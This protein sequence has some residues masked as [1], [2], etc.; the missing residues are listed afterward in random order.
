MS[1]IKA[2]A[3]QIGQSNTATENFTLEVPSSPDGTIKLA[4]GNAGATTQDVLSV[5]ASGNVAFAGITSLGDISNATVTATSTTTARD[6]ATRFADVINVLDFGADPTGAVDSTEAFQN[7]F[8]A[9]GGYI[10]SGNY[11]ISET[12]ITNKV[13][14]ICNPNAIIKRN[15]APN[16]TSRLIS[17]EIGSEGSNWNGGVI[18]GKRYFWK[19]IYNGYATANSWVEMRIFAS[20]ITISNVTINNAINFGI[21]LSDCEN[22]LLTNITTN[23]CTNNA[24]TS[25][26]NITINGFY[27]N[28]ADND[29][30]RLFVRGITFNSCK[31]CKFSNVYCDGATGDTE[32]I[33]PTKTVTGI[34]CLD[35]EECNLNNI[36]VTR[37]TGDIDHLAISI[38]S[39]YRCN[40]SDFNILDYSGVGLE[41]NGCNYMN[42]DRFIIDAYYHT[43]TY[44]QE[45]S[46]VGIS[47]HYGGDYPIGKRNR[48]VTYTSQPVKISNGQILRC[49]IGVHGRSGLVKYQDIS[50]IGCRTQGWRIEKESG[51]SFSSGDMVPNENTFVDCEAINCGYSGLSIRNGDNIK[52]LGGNY[53]NN[54]QES[55]ISSSLKYGVGYNT[56]S[57]QTDINNIV[58][59]SIVA[60]DTQDFIIPNGVTFKP[61]TTTQSWPNNTSYTY[62]VTLIGNKIVKVGQ[63]LKIVN[64]NGPDWIGRVIDINRDEAIL[65]FNT[66]TTF[67]ELNNTITLTG[68]WSSSGTKLIGV[69]TLAKTELYG[70]YWITNGTEWRQ[71]INVSDDET[72]TINS[73]FTTPFSNITINKLCTNL[74][75]IPS[76]D[77]GVRFTDSAI[78]SLYHNNIIAYNNKVGQLSISSIESVNGSLSTISNVYR[79][80]TVSLLDDTATSIPSPGAAGAGAIVTDNENTIGIACFTADPSPS[81]GFTG[82]SQF[83]ATTG[84]LNGT[85]GDD[86][87]ITVSAADDGK[88]YIENRR[89]GTRNITVMFIR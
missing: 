57:L 84:V 24:L 25:C 18:D 41:I 55:S 53:S 34:L 81:M 23:N 52:I 17:F 26:N 44:N 49:G 2:N 48:A 85:T 59:Q 87:C 74:E 80:Y 9:G 70:P 16:S 66:Q 64:S 13:N 5:D 12:N 43:T 3:I 22:V 78:K 86:F 8:N 58:V 60:S 1:L 88:F 83:R 30:S 76:Q 14:V 75:G 50:I 51:Q 65:A 42:F 10:P 72:I 63:Y 54:G 32:T 33:S 68:T 62:E 61:G 73:A 11:L 38:L 77:Y 6:L 29:E 15:I 47:V 35:L 46:N 71:V 69:G 37:M 67:T 40:F 19:S 36:S 31:F 20:N 82:T 45:G 79:S 21:A 28:N 27:S 7:F 89:G 4:R 56:P 39:S